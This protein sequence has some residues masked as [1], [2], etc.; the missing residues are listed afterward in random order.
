MWPRPDRGAPFG[1]G[2]LA[3]RPGCG[4]D[5]AGQA[6]ALGLGS[7]ARTRMAPLQGARCRRGR[8]P[9]ARQQILQPRIGGGDVGIA[10]VKVRPR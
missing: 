10:N 9:L 7:P 8:H 6:A 1:H 3:A 5:I 2:P 4:G